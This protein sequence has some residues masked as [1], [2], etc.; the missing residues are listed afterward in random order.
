MSRLE[1]TVTQLRSLNEDFRALSLQTT[2]LEDR[3]INTKAVTQA[4]NVK[5]KMQRFKTIRDASRNV[6]EALGR[7]CTKHQEHFTHFC[8]DTTDT[9]ASEDRQ[10]MVNFKVAFT[11]LAIQ[12]SLP[13]GSP[14]FFVIESIIRNY[15][16]GAFPQGKESTMKLLSTLKRGAEN[17]ASETLAKKANR[18]QFADITPEQNAQLCV[19]AK[20]KEPLRNLCTN[21]NFCDQLRLR[22]Q[23]P[24]APQ[25]C[26][27]TLDEEGHFRHLVYTA[28]PLL[29][30][31]PRNAR[32]MSLDTILS[33]FSQEETAHLPEHERLR[34]ARSLASAVLQY[35]ATPWLPSLYRSEDIYFFGADEKRLLDTPSATLPAPHLNV[36]VRGSDSCDGSSNLPPLTLAPNT[37]LFSLGVLLL[38]IA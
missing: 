12:G 25:T 38:E 19:V 34:L 3:S 6:Y 27:G 21:G 20:A 29:S 37:M 4:G 16:P 5:Q 7:S 33:M 11:H 9:S 23:Q 2:L 35:H 32:P 28:Q 36:T 1:K 26:L 17:E 31:S 18:V 30:V 22:S 14:I 13:V 8:L 15:P 10:A 24:E